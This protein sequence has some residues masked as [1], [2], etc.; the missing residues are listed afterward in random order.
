M[1]ERAGGLQPA[2][3]AWRRRAM[4][5]E[6]FDVLIVGGG[7][8]GFPLARSLATAGR[9]VALAER[10]RLGGSCVNFG[11]TP[12]KAALASAKL[13]YD[14]R[15]AG[16]FCVRVSGVSVDFPAVLARARGIADDMRRG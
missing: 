9:R 13:A 2:E 11:C 5:S 14:A 8:A 1:M 4:A 6:P 15:R 3:A 12:S 10:E 16:T 7:Q